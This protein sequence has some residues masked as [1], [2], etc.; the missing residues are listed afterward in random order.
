[1]VLHHAFCITRPNTKPYRRLALPRLICSQIE[2]QR[3]S[4]VS[5]FFITLN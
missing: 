3:D 5:F 1:L 2:K 4:Q